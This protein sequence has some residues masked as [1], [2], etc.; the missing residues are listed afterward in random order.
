MAKPPTIKNFSPDDQLNIA[1]LKIFTTYLSH[2]FS[3]YSEMIKNPDSDSIHDARVYC[4]RFQ[5]LFQIYSPL[6]ISENDNKTIQKIKKISAYLK[7]V[8]ELLGVVRDSE[9]TFQIIS[10][11]ISKYDE[12]GSASLMMLTSNLRSEKVSGTEWIKK[13]R[14]IKN[15]MLYKEQIENLLQEKLEINILPYLLETK[16][17]ENYQYL[18]SLKFNDMMVWMEKVVGHPENYKEI[19]KMRIDAKLLRYIL[20]ISP[21]SFSKNFNSALNQIKNFTET[22]GELH[23]LD[24]AA[25]VTTNYLKNLNYRFKAGPLIKLLREIDEKRK[26]L[27]SKIQD[28]IIKWDSFHLS[29]K[30]IKLN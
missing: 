11:I 5:A 1:L 18:I 13:S 25:K 20:E 15:F 26:E 9:V 6:L 3:N 30:I 7:K 19:H 10:K 2:L 16:F 24:I 27:F 22:S 29:E 17:K 23:D 4:R 8:I 28:K 14:K 12:P 21:E